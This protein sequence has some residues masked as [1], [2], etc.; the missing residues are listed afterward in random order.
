MIDLL[1]NGS[2]VRVEYEGEPSMLL[3]ELVFAVD[4]ILDDMSYHNKDTKKVIFDI[5]VNT[6]PEMKEGRIELKGGY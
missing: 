1:I 6:L 2:N 3:S 5:V 4:K